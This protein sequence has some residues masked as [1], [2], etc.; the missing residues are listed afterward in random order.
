[1]RWGDPGEAQLGS[2]GTTL[3]NPSW[4]SFLTL[5]LVSAPPASQDAHPHPQLTHHHLGNLPQELWGEWG[6]GE[7]AGIGRIGKAPEHWL[8]CRHREP[9]DQVSGELPSC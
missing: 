1:M 9:T 2:V 8:S 7:P 4:V 5:P 6:S 3:G